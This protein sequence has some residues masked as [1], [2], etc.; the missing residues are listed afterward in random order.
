MG[1]S[2]LSG[3]QNIAPAPDGSVWF[4]QSTKGNAARITDDGTITETK[5]VRKSDPFGITV[6]A[7]GNPWYTLRAANKIAEFQLR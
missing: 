5:V 3:P 2:T 4:T 7:Q 6:D 1:I